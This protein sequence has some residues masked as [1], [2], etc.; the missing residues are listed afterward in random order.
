MIGGK[1][2]DPGRVS[3]NGLDE[4]NAAAQVLR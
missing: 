2:S 1:Y 4:Y 3:E